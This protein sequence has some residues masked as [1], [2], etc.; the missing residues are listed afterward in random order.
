VLA[1]ALLGRDSAVTELRNAQ[2]EAGELRERLTSTQQQIVKLERDRDAVASDSDQLE[3]TII[4]LRREL[5]TLRTGQPQADRDE[6]TGLR[7]R[8]SRAEQQATELKR[9]RDAMASDNDELEATIIKLRR[10]LLAVRTSKARADESAASA[11]ERVRELQSRAVDRPRELILKIDAHIF[12]SKHTIL[13][14]LWA[15][16]YEAGQLTFK[17]PSA[18]VAAS[19]RALETAVGIMWRQ[20]TG[21]IGSPKVSDMLYDL[22]GHRLMPDS[23]WHLA[24]NIY[25][26]ASGIVHDGTNRAD[27]ALWIFF[28]AVQICEL[29]QPEANP[30][31][32]KIA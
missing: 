1:T 26:R 11:L 21:G 31:S 9:N 3:A 13:P 8:L 23:D 15:I 7:E 17:F 28:G 25:G 2:T 18:S 6:A 20:A 14:D 24:K 27:L 30:E 12:D 10:D 22:R 5:L 32:G 19:R 29:V 4:Q 16:L